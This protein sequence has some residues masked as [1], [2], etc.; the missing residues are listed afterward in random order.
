MTKERLQDKNSNGTEQS[1]SIRDS[2]LSTKDLRRFNGKFNRVELIYS[3]NAYSTSPAS[4]Y[5]WLIL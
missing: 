1:V 3:S 5:P 4:F 2:Q